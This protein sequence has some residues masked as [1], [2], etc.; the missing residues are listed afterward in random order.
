VTA[1]HQCPTPSSSKMLRRDRFVTHLAPLGGLIKWCKISTFESIRKPVHR[2]TCI[3]EGPLTRSSWTVPVVGATNGVTTRLI[4]AMAATWEGPARQIQRLELFVELAVSG[5]HAATKATRHVEQ[6]REV[7]RVTNREDPF[8]DEHAYRRAKSHAEEVECFATSE[9]VRGFPYLF[10]LALVKLWSVVEASVD[11][12]LIAALSSPEKWRDFSLVRELKGPLVEFAGAP[13]SQQVELLASELKLAVKSDLKPGAGKFEAM[14]KPVELGGGVPDEIRRTLL[15][16]AEVRNGVV[17]RAGLADQRLVSSCPWLALKTGDEIR[18]SQL[19]LDM[20]MS[21][22]HWYGLALTDRWQRWCG[23]PGLDERHSAAWGEVLRLTKE[24]F[25]I[26]KQNFES[27]GE[28]QT[29]P[30]KEESR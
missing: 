28:S 14:L 8:A 2:F 24:L 13:P 1:A 11:D 3:G 7:A 20:Y 17:H 6:R 22:S 15:E 16:M 18:I 5:L 12:L 23:L 9:H 25:D 30:E 27:N 29:P 19:D 10:T 4:E 26:R 21:A